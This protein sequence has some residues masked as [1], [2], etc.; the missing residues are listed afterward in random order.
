M[1]SNGLLKLAFDAY[2]ANDRVR[3]KERFLK[4][5]EVDPNQPLVHYYLALGLRERGR[6][7][8]GEEPP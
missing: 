8:G 7:R 5:L 3:A 6:K 2:D 4:V 1:P